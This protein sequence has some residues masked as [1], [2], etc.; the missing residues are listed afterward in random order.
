EEP[1]DPTVWLAVGAGALAVQIALLVAGLG[2]L[3]YWAWVVCTDDLLFMLGVI[4]GPVA[5]SGLGMGCSLVWW[6]GSVARRL[7][8]WDGSARLDLGV[9]ATGGT[10]VGAWLLMFRLPA[11][12]LLVL[13]PSLT[14]GVVAAMP[15][16]W[17]TSSPRS[18]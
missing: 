18:A 11:A 16:V 13:A 9:V 5:I 3:A 7:L 15:S 4:V 14:A 8:A 10:L 1:I 17:R 2:F 12:G 6:M